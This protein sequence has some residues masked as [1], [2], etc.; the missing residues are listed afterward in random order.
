LTVPIEAEQ[1]VL[2]IVYT[3]SP[4]PITLLK[5]LANCGSMYNVRPRDKKTTNQAKNTRKL[6][7]SHLHKWDPSFSHQNV[8][9]VTV[10]RLH[11]VTSGNETKFKPIPGKYLPCG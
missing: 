11:K 1:G 9:D 4:S 10:F 5:I 8:P 7:P 2:S 6:D 3:T